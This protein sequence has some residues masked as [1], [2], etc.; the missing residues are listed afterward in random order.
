M[1]RPGRGGRRA[2][3]DRDAAA[4]I[5]FGKPVLVGN[6]VTDK[7]RPAAAERR[8][9][10]ESGNN[11]TLVTVPR[12]QLQ[13]HLAGKEPQPLVLGCCEMFDGRTNLG[14]ALRDGAIM[15]RQSPALVLDP[16]AR[17]APGE[18]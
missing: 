11:R 8:L 14:P 12:L 17:P 10:E 6:V 13:K 7:Y 2:D 18:V 5:D 16:R 4:A 15:Q 3:P 9:G 1:S